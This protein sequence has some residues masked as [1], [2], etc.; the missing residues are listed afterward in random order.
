MTGD[1]TAAIPLAAHPDPVLAYEVRDGDPV[2][3]ATNPAFDD[4]VAVDAEGR[5]VGA[6]F[7]AFDTVET[8]GCEPPAV[9]VAR[10]DS[11]AGI[12][13]DG[14]AGA[15]SYFVRIVDAD[16]GDGTAAGGF[17]VFGDVTGLLA[18]VDTVGVGEVAS[19]L[20]HDL[21]NPLDVAK[22]H[23]RAAEETGADEHFAAVADAHDR[24]N[25]IIRDVLT[26]ARGEAV[27]DPT[28]GVAIQTAVEDAWQSVE[29]ADAELRVADDLPTTTADPDRLRRLL[30]NLFRNA[31]EHGSTDN[32][33]A[34][35]SDDAVEHGS[36]SP[37]SQAR[38]DAVEHGST[39]ADGAGVTVTVGALGDGDDGFY[40]ADDGPGIP[41]GERDAV[42]DPG[43]TVEGG[44][45]GLGLS[46]VQRVASAHDWSLALTDSDDGGARFEIRLQ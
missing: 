21:R 17:L 6:V 25:Q 5:P 23:L 46:I 39:D 24:M 30:E 8:T 44:G 10:I 13:L 40:V 45:T 16:G 20:S 19:V 38:Q 12:Y 14:G 9:H 15:R 7:D 41:P 43:Y 3:T 26:L 28:D 35:Q 11:D 2:V 22:A 29:T 18:M 36:T 31:V 42:F 4:A 27:V 37:D 33:T 34:P 1:S 32:R